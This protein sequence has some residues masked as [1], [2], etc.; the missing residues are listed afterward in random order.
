[1]GIDDVGGI[2]CESTEELEERLRT[3]YL[4][5]EEEKDME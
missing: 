1:L 4:F 2:V 3:V 5:S